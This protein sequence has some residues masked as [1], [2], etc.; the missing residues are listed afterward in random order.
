MGIFIL[1]G[2]IIFLEYYTYTGIKS[3]FVENEYQSWVSIFYFVQSLFLLFA[4]YQ[5]LSVSRGEILRNSQYNIWLGI[6]MISL[7]TKFIFCCLLFI[8]DSGRMAGLVYNMFKFKFD[9]STE[10][11]FI[12]ERR[13]FLT[14]ASFLLA[15]IPFVGML[16]GMAKGKYR[17]TIKNVSLVF[18]DLPK[19]FD[20]LKIVQI[21]DIHSGSFDN[22]E[23]VKKGIDMINDQNGD[24]VLF[25]GDLINSLKDE[26]NPFI[27]LFSSIKA[28]IGKYAVLG[29][30]DYYGYYGTP[31]SEKERYW[32]D[33]M[34]KYKLMGFQLLNNEHKYI[35][36]NDEKICL[37]GVENWG[38][39]RHFPKHGDLEKATKGIGKDDFTILMSHDPS[40]WDHHVLPNE[41]HFHLTLSGHTHGMQF[42][43]DLPGLKWSPVKYRYPR[44]MGLYEEAGQFLYVNRG[45]GFL[46]FPGRVGMWPE[47]TVIELKSLKDT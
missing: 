1:L 5:L 2:L 18:K 40:H 39:G 22:I 16:Y 23:E 25:T 11:I 28:K 42:G 12:P 6:L 38:A 4:V 29:N 46:A 43:I 15:G 34:K 24:L 27:D 10:N 7:V 13:K 20:G 31:Q 47:I 14:Q 17:Y 37:V 26:I 32:N 45:F 30:H 44:W 35:N 41:K 21:S 8:Q 19:S 9:E 3:L 36:I 33:F